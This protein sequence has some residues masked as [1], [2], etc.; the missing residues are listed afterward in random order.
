M[1]DA[2]MMGVEDKNPQPTMD[3]G[4]VGGYDH[5]RDR[6]ESTLLQSYLEGVDYITGENIMKTCL[7]QRWVAANDKIL[8]L[9]E[10]IRSSKFKKKFTVLA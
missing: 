10:V 3:G 5:G 9:Y 2:F 7:N 8:E 4:S 1:T 6:F